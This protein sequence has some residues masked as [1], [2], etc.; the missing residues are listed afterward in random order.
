V[1]RAW[2][3][4][5]TIAV[6]LGAGSCAG[7]PGDRN[8]RPTHPPSPATSGQVAAAP[9]PEVPPPVALAEAAPP[10]AS[11]QAPSPAPSA[12]PDGIYC[13]VVGRPGCGPDGLAGMHKSAIEARFGEPQTRNAN[14]WVYVLPRGCAYE[15]GTMTV[16]F[17]RDRVVKA[18]ATQHITGQ[19]CE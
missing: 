12:P 2:P 15:K 10:V 4:A 18:T 3:I 6:S 19:H 17:A 9:S 7:S 14:R 8:A 5:A 13:N 1:H 16:H 11:A